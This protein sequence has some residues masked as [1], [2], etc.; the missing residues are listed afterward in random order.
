MHDEP[1]L[2]S[3]VKPEPPASNHGQGEGRRPLVVAVPDPSL[4]PPLVCSI[5]PLAAAMRGTAL[6]LSAE[7][8]G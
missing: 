2:G 1:T 8:P 5:V 3:Q 7:R 6:A 4:I